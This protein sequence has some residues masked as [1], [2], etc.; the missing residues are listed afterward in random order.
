MNGQL[1]PMGQLR[2]IIDAF[3]DR[4]V[5]DLMIGLFLKSIPKE[6]LKQRELEDVAAWKRYSVSYPGRSLKEEYTQHPV[7]GGH[8]NRPKKILQETLCEF[9]VSA[10]LKEAWLA[11]TEVLGALITHDSESRCDA[12]ASRIDDLN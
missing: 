5:L 12:V 3:V 6:R 4:V 1:L 8:F 10:T 7:T 11:H 9:D 2:P